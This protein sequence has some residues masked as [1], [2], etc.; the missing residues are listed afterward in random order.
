[1]NHHPAPHAAFGD[2]RPRAECFLLCDYARAEN[3]KLY[4]VGGGWNQILTQQLP[5]DYGA[6]IASKLIIPGGWLG[7]SLSITIELRDKDGVRLGDPVYEG[8]VENSP[9]PSTAPLEDPLFYRLVIFMGSEVK[10]ILK[11]IG[12]Y[13]LCLLLNEVVVAETSFSV[14][15]TSSSSRPT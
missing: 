1:M 4:I 12:T 9:L 5:A 2:E 8:T 6:Y 13:S 14:L 3:Q 15:L 7:D 11:E 10:M